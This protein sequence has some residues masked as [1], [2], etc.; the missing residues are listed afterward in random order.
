MALRPRRYST[1]FVAPHFDDVALSCG[2]TVALEARRGPVLIVTVFAGE[3]TGPLNPFARFQHERWGTGEQTLAIR[4]EE[5]Q[6]ACASLGAEHRWL[7]FPD[8][9][10]RGALYL[11]DE[12]LFGDVNPEDQPTV[13]AVHDELGALLGELRP[14]QIYLPLG[15][16]GHVDHRICQSAVP[17][18]WA[19]VDS[20]F[21]YEDFPY[22]VTTGALQDALARITEPVRP[23]LVDVTGSMDARLRAIATYHSQV[24]TIF[25]DYGA[26]E[27]VT[28]RYAATIAPR[29]RSLAERFWEIEPP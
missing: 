6:D 13:Q 8:A 24:A 17:A 4:R 16:G 27:E 1:V 10:Y 19:S 18:L 28:R 22:A 3:P 5:D 15:I 9:I 20:I 7:G 12:Y 14:E 21:L 23:R 25:R 2:G 11:A 26:Y 29:R